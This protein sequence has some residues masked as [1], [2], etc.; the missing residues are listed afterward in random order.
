MESKIDKLD[1]VETN[2]KPQEEDKKDNPG[3]K[4]L[5]TKV[6]NRFK[7]KVI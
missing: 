5:I 7:T 4:K 2:D 3:S 1:K 6:D